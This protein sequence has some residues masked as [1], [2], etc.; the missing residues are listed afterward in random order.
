VATKEWH[1]RHDMEKAGGPHLGS[2]S[3]LY[4]TSGICHLAPLMHIKRVRTDSGKG[5]VPR[6]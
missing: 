5:T 6:I 3:Q 4:E 2:N 1:A